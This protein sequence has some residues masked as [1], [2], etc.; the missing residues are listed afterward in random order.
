MQF[1]I[2]LEKVIIYNRLHH[3]GRLSGT[4]VFLLDK[5]D[6]IVGTFRIVDASNMNEIEIDI[7]NFNLSSGS[8]DIGSV[9]IAGSAVMNNDQFVVRGSGKGR[10]FTGYQFF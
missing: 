10:S 1:E 4:T 8:I 9:G 5:S 2:A 7:A 6:Y 3:K